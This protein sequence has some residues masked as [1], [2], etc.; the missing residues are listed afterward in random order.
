MR[1]RYSILF[2]PLHVIIDFLGLNAAFV[3]AYW[4]E[5]HSLEAIA[6]SPYASL[7][8]LFN[9]IWLLDILLFKP[10]IYPRQLFKSLH[11][12]KQL[13]LLTFTHAAIIALFWVAIQG[14]YYSRE[15]LLI[16][17]VLFLCFGTIFRIGGVL[18]LNEY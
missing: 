6:D 16:T 13:L 4:I 5:F 8:W 10:Y 3:G 2:F 12:I 1:H 11:L 14:Y 15:H 18:F 17:Y 9:A 7:W